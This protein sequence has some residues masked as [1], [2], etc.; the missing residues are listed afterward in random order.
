MT[1][2][3]LLDIFFNDFFAIHFFVED[4]FLFVNRAQFTISTLAKA[5]PYD[6]NWWPIL[7]NLFCRKNLKSISDQDVFIFDLNIPRNLQRYTPVWKFLWRR[8]QYLGVINIPKAQLSNVADNANNVACFGGI[9]H[10]VELYF[11]VFHFRLLFDLWLLKLLLVLFH[12]LDI[13]ILLMHFIQGRRHR[14]QLVNLLFLQQ[15][16]FL[17]MFLGLHTNKGSSLSF[18]K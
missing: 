6:F 13:Q 1:A 11:G 5:F 18:D 9:T 15:M 17:R 7:R 3:F 4:D 12:L 14:W 2:V 16:H 8:F 10:H